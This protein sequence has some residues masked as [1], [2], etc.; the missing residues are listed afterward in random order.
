M[1]EN[2]SGA[3]RIVPIVGHPIAQVRAPVRIT[4]AFE[5]RGVDAICVPVHVE[6]PNLARFMDA[7]RHFKNAA[8]VV[9]TVPHKIAA[10]EF[11]DG[12]SSLA[13]SLQ[14]V[15]VIKRTDDGLFYGD[16]FDGVAMVDVCRDKGCVFEGRRALLLGAGGAGTAI[17]QAVAAAGVSELIIADLDRERS[18][19]VAGRLSAAGHAV[20]VGSAEAS[21]FD[22]IINATP[23]GMR[24]GDPLPV[25]QAALRPG[26]FVGDVVTSPE[27]PALIAAARSVGCATSTGSDMS[28]KVCE[29][30]AD[31]LADC[32]DVRDRFSTRDGKPL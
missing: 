29:L 12:V 9:F 17:A 24:D 4:R 16:M 31:F 11:C 26:V 25:P 7:F 6:P 5:S 30:I 28:N 18:E 15:N 8:G 1:L 23:M 22:I 2:Y 10:Y 20:R 13:R 14:S 21:G 3:T 19:T 32:T 27:I